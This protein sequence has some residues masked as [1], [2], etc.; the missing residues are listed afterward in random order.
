MLA[1][2]LALLGEAVTE[3]ALEQGAFRDKY[4]S[5]EKVT[6][7]KRLQAII[8]DKIRYAAERCLEE[9][10]KGE[11]Y[12]L[13]PLG[14]IE[15]LDSLTPESL[16]QSYQDWLANASFDLYVAGD[17]TLEEVRSLVLKSFRFDQGEPSGYTYP[18]I[19]SNVSET[20]TI[21]ERMEVSQGKLNMGLRAN[22]GY[23]DDNYPAA[24][25]Y[26]GIL[27]G[28]PHSKLFL[29]VREKESL[30]YYAASRLDG[31]KGIITIQ[32]G[33]E[34]ANFERAADIIREQLEHMREGRINDLEISQTKAMLA[35]HLREI[36][37][38]AFEMIGFDFN[39]ILSGRVRT[40]GELL[41]EVERVTKEDVARVAQGV[42]LDTIYFLRDGKEA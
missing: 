28:Y 33:I 24:L 23:G 32:S 16:Y 7:Q 9:M 15:D 18:D 29:N 31:H 11:P 41:L 17:T 37:D 35:N 6:L 22:V 25:M 21:V 40:S 13:H 20:K 1:S 26:N 12:R 36:Q 2:A 10:C 30:A 3:P 8:N 34:I 42:Q 4:V 39:A 14:R 19:R 27:G 5:A 38:S